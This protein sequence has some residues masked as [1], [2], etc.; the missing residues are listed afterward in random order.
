MYDE[1][2]HQE[3]Q[4]IFHDLYEGKTPK[5]I[6]IAAC[7]TVEFAIQY[8]GL[9]TLEAQWN[10]ETLEKSF[11]KVT[12]DF[13]SDVLPVRDA[14]RF[15]VFYQILEARNFVMGSQGFLQH[16]EISGMEADEYD[17]FIKDPLAFMLE[18]ALPRLYPALDTDPISRSLVMAKAFKAHCDTV[19]FLNGVMIP[20]LEAEYGKYQAPPQSFAMTEVPMDFIADQLRGFKAFSMD[21]RRHSGK[22]LEACEAIQDIMLARAI[23]PVPSQHNYTFIPLHMAPYMR[24]K[25]F[26]KLYYPGFKKTVDGVAAAGGKSSLFIE[27]DWMRYL[28]ALYDLPEN[29]IMR[30]EFGDAKIIKEKLGDRHIISGLYPLGLLKTGT[31]QECIDKAK[32]MIDILAPGG[33]Y[34]FDFDKNIITTDSVNIENLKAVLETYRTCG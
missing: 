14:V 27:H 10:P 26:Y 15:P 11:R 16:P 6:P 12:E 21:V 7:G 19:G 33:H 2:L 32:E 4:E 5:R 29:T 25:D 24:E 28:D 34:L 13:Y 3:R 23:P 22:I 30:F 9:N 20:K 31:K 17:A 18:T 1:N 8:S